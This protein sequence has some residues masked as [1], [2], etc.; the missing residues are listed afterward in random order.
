MLKLAEPTKLTGHLSFV[1]D[2]AESPQS[3]H[4]Y[5]CKDFSVTEIFIISD[6]L[7]VKHVDIH[8]H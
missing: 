6:Q 8:T 5:L 7:K 4:H 2:R 3:F 1:P